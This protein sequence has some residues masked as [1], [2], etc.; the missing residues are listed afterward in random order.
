MMLRRTVMLWTAA[1]AVLLI[2]GCNGPTEKGKEAREHANAR[3]NEMRAG[4]EWDMAR[5]AYEVGDLDAARKRVEASISYNPEVPKSHV[6]LGR[7]HFEKGNLE[8][9]QQALGRAV[10]INPEFAD[11]H[12]CLGLV[13][14]RMQRFD[15]AFQSY[16]K[17]YELGDEDV[18]PLVAAIEV[19][20]TDGRL[21]EAYG[22]AT[23]ESE[24]FPHNA[25]LRQLIGQIEQIRGNHEKAVAHF[26]EARLLAPENETVREDLVLALY[27]AR[28]FAE[29]EFEL[30]RMLKE[31]EHA[32]RR[33]LRHMQADC[34]IEIDRAM[35]ARDVLMQLVA[36]ES[37][38][39]RAWSTLGFLA[40]TLGDERRVR[41]A[42]DRLMGLT[43]NEPDGYLLRAMWEWDHGEPERA[44]RMIE[45]AVELSAAD[46]NPHLLAGVWCSKLGREAE[47]IAHFEQARRINPADVRAGRLLTVVSTTD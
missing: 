20:I 43:P 44:L 10:E 30:Q 28:R 14:E 19:L 23:A 9:A 47:A 17:A 6:L 29:C 1:A 24:R 21:D 32:G 2:A 41:Q 35:E 33:D 15:D 12:Y 26:E 27:A 31:K 13:Y 45:R 5:Q 46:P 8:A 11:A 42:G 37:S 22:F 18:F 38:D 16:S 36:E 40:Q 25:A 4:T 34:L 39:A 3:W 7:I